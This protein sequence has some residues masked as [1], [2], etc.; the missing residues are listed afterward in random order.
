MP[1]ARPYLRSK[2]KEKAQGKH[3]KIHRTEDWFKKF[4]W[5]QKLYNEMLTQ[6]TEGNWKTNVP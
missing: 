6:A 3:P 5:E 2:K 4:K 1:Y